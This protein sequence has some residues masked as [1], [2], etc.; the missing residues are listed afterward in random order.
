M[1]YISYLSSY[2]SRKFAFFCLDNVRGER[3]RFEKRL[4]DCAFVAAA[5]VVVVVFVDSERRGARVTVASYRARHE[6]G[7]VLIKIVA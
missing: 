3:S 2:P 4:R 5:V 1:K 6:T 7:S